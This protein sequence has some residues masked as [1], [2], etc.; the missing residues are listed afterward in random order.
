MSKPQEFALPRAPEDLCFKSSDFIAPD[1]DVDNFLH[2]HRKLATLE[3][4]RDDLG[5]Y[6]KIL[7]SAMIELINKDYA[8][9]VN[10][11]KDLIG[12]DKAIDQL[13]CPL[14]QIREEVLQIHQ[15]LD[16]ATTEMSNG[17]EEDRRIREEKQCMHSLERVYKS[18]E[19]LKHILEESEFHQVDRLERGATEYNQLMFHASRCI[20]Y[21]SPDI[22]ESIDALEKTL[23]TLLSRQLL[24]LLQERSEG[25]REGLARCLRIYVNLDRIREAEDL[26]RRRIVAPVVEDV[27]VERNIYN[28]PRGLQGLYDRLLEVLT[29][30]MK[31]LLILEGILESDEGKGFNFIVN[32]YWVEVEEKIELRLKSIFAAG[33]P[34]L[35]HQRF[36]E[37]LEYLSAVG[38]HCSNSR[39]LQEFKTHPLYIQFMKKWNLPVYFQIRFQEIA[40]SVEQLLGESASPGAIKP[41]GNPQDFSLNQTEVVWGA[42]EKCWS[43]GIFL[44]QL[45]HQFWKL[46]LQICSRFRVWVDNSLR[47]TWIWSSEGGAQG[48]LEFLVLLY[49]DVMKFE[50]KLERLLEFA[51]GR[52]G[53]LFG[54]ADDVLRV[55]L[56]EVR[57]G[58]RADRPG[59]SEEIVRELLGKSLESLK[60]VSDIPRLFRRT[61]RERPT[62]ACAYVRNAVGGL[63]EF[64]EMYKDVGHHVVDQWML[65]A[66]SQL[67]EQYF[68]SVKDVLESVQKTEESLRR[69]KKIRDKSSGVSQPETQGITDDEKIRVQ[70]EIDVNTFCDS[71]KSFN[72]DV[73]SIGKLEELREIVE[74][75]V[76]N[77]S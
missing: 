35:F 46:N 19:K 29:V 43:D 75:A 41:R 71:V 13:E 64:R 66:L 9:F 52:L 7:R 5:V 45:L 2:D 1:F 28:E 73:S 69:L 72:I 40:G 58:L 8:D 42:L 61:M 51:E 38:R 22:Q 14:G 33:N 47:Q 50:E 17:L 54:R 31:G 20:Q 15:T 67:A 77:K 4:M 27:I 39:I 56:Q 55:S 59:I 24:S 23:M 48:R 3:T 70:L 53:E 26:V 68:I 36:R 30:E 32:S 44:Q 11:S 49:S 65:M 76:K 37:T 62:Q 60:Q 18:L 21:I 12:L 6:L 63:K 16:S 57:A 34:D 25:P 10:L 74:A